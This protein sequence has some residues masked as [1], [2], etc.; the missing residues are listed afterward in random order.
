[1]EFNNHFKLVQEGASVHREVLSPLLHVSVTTCAINQ[2]KELSEPF[3]RLL[4]KA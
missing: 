1:M 4:P 3:T 2:M